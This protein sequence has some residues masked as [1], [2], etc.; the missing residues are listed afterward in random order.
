VIRRAATLAACACV[1]AGLGAAPAAASPGLRQSTLL[2]IINTPPVPLPDAYS[3]VHDRKLRVDAPGLLGNDLDVDG[4]ELEAKLVNGPNHGQL[5]LDHDGSFTYEPDPGYVGLDGFTYAAHDGK[6]GV[7]ALVALT[8]TNVAPVGRNDS[9]TVKQGQ[10]LTV[11]RPGVLKNDDDADGDA[12]T[13]KLVNGPDHGKLD[14]K[15][16]GEFDYEPDA[17]FAG[18]DVFTYRALDGADQS[19]VVRVVID[20]TP[21]PTPAPTPAPTPTPEPTPRPT[22]KP[23]KPDPDP[24]HDPRPTASP[25]TGGHE[26][27][28]GGAGGKGGDGGNGTGRG[29][30]AQNGP[31][32]STAIAQ[33]AVALG[34]A[35][36]LARTDTDSRSGPSVAFDAGMAAAFDG[37]AWQVP[38]LVLS[39]PGLLVVVAVGLQVIGALAWLPLVRRRLGGD[40]DGLTP[41]DRR[42]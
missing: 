37:F 8:V 25:D 32:P 13:T 40:G 7:S 12:L 34:E 3:V 5:N 16:Q 29:G 22:P 1:L 11:D 9:Y 38:A 28:S 19:G 33:P 42:A 27:G 20:V 41:P 21:K 6:I 23:D 26:N 4:D 18:S 31:G 2:E 15:E 10:K 30:G 24:T 35:L 14:L 17:S 36:A 39:V